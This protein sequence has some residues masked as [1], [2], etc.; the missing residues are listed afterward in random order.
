MYANGI[1]PES[2]ITPFARAVL[3]DLPAPNLPGNSNNFVSL[4]RGTQYDDKGDIRYDQYFNDRLAGFVRYSQRSYRIFE[5]ASVPPPSGGNANGDVHVKNW[6]VVPG[7]TWTMSPTSVLEARVGIDYTEAGKTP[8]GLGLPTDQYQIPNLPSDPRFTGGLY[9]LSFSGGLSQLG[10]QPSNP[11]FQNPFVINPKVNYSK[12]VSRHTLKMGYEFQSINTEIDDFNPKYGQDNYQG[13]FSNPTGSTRGLTSAQQQAYSLADFMFGARN[14]YQLNNAAIVNYRQRM[15]FLYLQDDFK[16]NSRLTLNLGLRYEFATPQWER[17]NK[18]VNFDPVTQQLI[19][20]KGGSI[21]DRAL[22]HPD[23]NNFAP[24]IGLAYRLSNKTVIRSGYGI[25]YIHFNR[26]GGENLLAFNGPNIVNAQINQLPSQGVCGPNSAPSTCFRPTWM[27]FPE[28]FAVPENFSPTRSRVN[29]I[30]AD[31]RTSY[32]QTWHFTVQQELAKNF[33]LD[34]G[35]IGNRSVGLMILGDYNQA[36]P[37]APGE[38]TPLQQ[39]RPLPGY[40]FIQ[41]AFGGGFATYNALQ[42][43]LEKRYTAG[44]YLLNSFT[45]SK[46]IDNASGHLETANGDNS[47]VNMANLASEKGPSSYDQTFN[48]VTTFIYDLPFG[49]GRRY[50]ID[51]TFANLDVGKSYCFVLDFS[52]ESQI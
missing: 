36:R 30:P 15:H 26:L 32:V 24:R 47:R 13:L 46:G 38:N 43:K 1:I 28:N 34:I 42:V 37:N 39:R 12:I 45:W 41:E 49:K 23:R 51:N 7:V 52:F 6:Q 27:G 50:N 18:L 29:Y 22:I 40:D 35:Y 10:R 16:V 44:I 20:A 48:N 21:Y 8:I 19:Q 17:D 4:P 25:S 33:L 2:D 14:Q 5:G 31:Y 11:Q 9:T 3:N